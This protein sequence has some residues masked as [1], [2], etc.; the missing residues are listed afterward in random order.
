VTFYPAAVRNLTIACGLLLWLRYY[1]IVR[2]YR[3]PPD[4]DDTRRTNSNG[5]IYILRCYYIY[6]LYSLVVL[7]YFVVVYFLALHLIMKSFA[8]IVFL[9]YF[10]S[11]I[12]ITVLFDSQLLLPA[13]LYPTAVSCQVARDRA[14][15]V[16]GDEL[17]FIRPA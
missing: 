14:A 9:L 15:G 3:R 1:R 16:M 12:F 11:H 6:V 5:L 10:V 8:E 13:W 2:L 7:G 17:L 4:S